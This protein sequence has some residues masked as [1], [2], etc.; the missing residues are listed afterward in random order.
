MS[1][2]GEG[3]RAS[4]KSILEDVSS[5]PLGKSTNTKPGAKVRLRLIKRRSCFIT[6]S[7]RC[8]LGPCHFISSNERERG[9][10]VSQVPSLFIFLINL[11]LFVCLPC[12]FLFSDRLIVFYSTIQNQLFT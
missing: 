1:A 2:I 10:G 3:A 4:V 5:L 7:M 12:L 8:V 6:E 9:K 11:V